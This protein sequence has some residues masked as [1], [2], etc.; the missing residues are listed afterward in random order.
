MLGVCA[1]GG[2]GKTT[3][4]TQLCRDEQVIRMIMIS[5]SLARAHSEFRPK[6]QSGL[7]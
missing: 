2:C 7:A 3:S 5:L 6:V 4:V 1:P